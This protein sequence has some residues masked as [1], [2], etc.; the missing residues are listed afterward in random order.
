MSR[1]ILALV[2][3]FLLASAPALAAPVDQAGWEARKQPVTLA[4]G[5]R[6]SYVELGDPRGEPLLLLHGYTDSSRSWTILAPWLLE[7]RLLI[8]DQRGH[9]AADAPACCYAIADY[10]EDA[11]QFLDALGVERAAVAGHSMGSMVAMELAAR[12]PGR[13]SKLV[14]AGST[15]L[16][17]IRKD[18]WLWTEVQALKAPLSADTPFMKEWSPANS[19]T[20][21]DPAFAAAAMGEIL[22]VKLHVW[23]GVLGAMDGYDPGPAARRVRVPTLILSGAKDPLF[24]AEHHRALAAAIPQAQ[25]HHFPDFGHNPI[26]ERPEE[27]GP[28]LAAFLAR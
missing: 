12:H 13:V 5:V 22:K 19:P 2:L 11:R 23:R 25:A 8:P 16:P 3:L 21:V 6:L 1:H 15:A 28:I 7:H 20:P 24:P 18:H 10:A 26:W 9:G 4:N 27:V 14:L 17:P